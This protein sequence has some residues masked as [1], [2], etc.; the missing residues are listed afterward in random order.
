MEFA[1]SVV[2]EFATCRVG[3]NVLVILEPKYPGSPEMSG[4]VRNVAKGRTD[5]GRFSH[6]VA[7]CTLAICVCGEVLVSLVIYI[8]NNA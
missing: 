1:R 2:M 8:E 6:E 4:G 5:V 3:L 7:G